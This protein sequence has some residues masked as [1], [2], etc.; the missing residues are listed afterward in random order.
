MNFLLIT[1]IVISHATKQNPL[2]YFIITESFPTIIRERINNEAKMAKTMN[3]IL[4]FL[5]KS[6][7]FKM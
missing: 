4:S 2:T 7:I 3:F 1:N 5:N 6:L